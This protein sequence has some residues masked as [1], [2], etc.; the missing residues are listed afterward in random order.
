MRP[1]CSLLLLHDC[2]VFSKLY[3]VFQED[4]NSEFS[5]SAEYKPPDSEE[6]EEESTER[7]KGIARQRVVKK[8]EEPSDEEIREHSTT[9]IPFRSW[10]EECV[11][12]KAKEDAHKRRAEEESANASTK[13]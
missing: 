12:G 3:S 4:S 13:L 11:K 7:R 6:I 2:E 10:C 9:H 1:L 8:P 5:S